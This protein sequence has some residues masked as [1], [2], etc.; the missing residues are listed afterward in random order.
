[1]YG[2]KCRILEKKG[3]TMQILF[4]VQLFVFFQ[5]SIHYPTVT[6]FDVFRNYT[7]LSR[8]RVPP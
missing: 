3:Q 1:M 2:V 7:M 6:Y 5:V 4:S 8:P